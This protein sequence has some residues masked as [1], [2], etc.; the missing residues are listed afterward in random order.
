MPSCREQDG[1]R[2][3]DRPAGQAATHDWIFQL[4]AGS[5]SSSPHQQQQQQQRTQHMQQ[6][7]HTQQ[8]QHVQHTQQPQR[9]QQP[10]HSQRTQ[11]GPEALGA[12]SDDE[13]CN[14]A[15]GRESDDKLWDRAETGPRLDQQNRS[16]VAMQAPALQPSHPVIQHVTTSL[17]AGPEDW[18]FSIGSQQ[19]QV[20]DQ[21]AS[22]GQERTGRSSLSEPRDM[23]YR[24]QPR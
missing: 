6:P 23:P 22:V 2:P 11:H 8:S 18:M 10:Q 12:C 7:Q 4:T 3:Q 15:P 13:D 19:A 5:P 21:L 24:L 20:L 16:P 1:P 17:V 14:S 9:T